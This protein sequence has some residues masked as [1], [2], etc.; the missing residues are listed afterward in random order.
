MF[1][2]LMTTAH[3]EPEGSQDGGCVDEVAQQTL[4]KQDMLAGHTSYCLNNYCNYLSSY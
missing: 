3:E 2:V 1:I 4:S